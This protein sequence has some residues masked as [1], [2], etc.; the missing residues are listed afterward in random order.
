[1][2]CIDQHGGCA[3]VTGLT[4]LV[5]FQNA[6]LTLKK[7]TVCLQNSLYSRTPTA[8]LHFPPDLKGPESSIDV[9]YCDLILKNSIESTPSPYTRPATKSNCP[10]NSDSDQDGPRATVEASAKSSTVQTMFLDRVVTTKR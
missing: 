2:K 7:S 8:E 10:R 5:C 6:L 3:S 9:S 4:L 1:M